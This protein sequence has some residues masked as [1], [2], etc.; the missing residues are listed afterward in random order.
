MLMPPFTEATG[1]IQT[2]T[3]VRYNSLDSSLSPLE[4]DST[5]MQVTITKVSLFDICAFKKMVQAGFS[6]LVYLLLQ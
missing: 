2:C 3:V 4:Y 1:R 5:P 6:T